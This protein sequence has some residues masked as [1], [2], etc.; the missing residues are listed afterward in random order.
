MH[1][2]REAVAAVVVEHVKRRSEYAAHP[3]MLLNWR[4]QVRCWNQVLYGTERLPYQANFYTHILDHLLSYPDLSSPR[5]VNVHT[6]RLQETYLSKDYSSSLNRLAIIRSAPISL[7]STTLD[8]AFLVCIEPSRRPFWIRDHSILNVQHIRQSPA[9][10][11]FEEG[12]SR[13]FH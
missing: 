5:S 1:G 3:R 13:P 7:S 4:P 11:V 9:T 10:F 12:S 8:L 2:T 6:S